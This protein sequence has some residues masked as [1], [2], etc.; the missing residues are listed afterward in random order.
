LLGFSLQRVGHL[1]K[2][3]LNRRAARKRSVA[4]RLEAGSE[5]SV[6]T[7]LRSLLSAARRLS[8]LPV[9]PPIEGFL[10]LLW[11]IRA[12][13]H[14]PTIP[15]QSPPPT[16]PGPP[17]A[18]GS[19]YCRTCSRPAACSR[20]STPSSPRSTRPSPAMGISSPPASPCSS[21]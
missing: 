15:P 3:A 14:P 6:A 4:A 8:A 21:R 20:A 10:E 17:R 18:G 11:T 13:C 7:R 2:E 5:R 12:P 1:S 16:T 9:A 19:T